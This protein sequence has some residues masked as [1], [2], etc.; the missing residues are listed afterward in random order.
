MTLRRDKRSYA[1]RYQD[2]QTQIKDC[3][4]EVGLIGNLADNE[5]KHGRLASDKSPQCGC[6][7]GVTPRPK[8]RK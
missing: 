8:V 4:I 3:P 1:E 7:P 2:L 6:F 5:C